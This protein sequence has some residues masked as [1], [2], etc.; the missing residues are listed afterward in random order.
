MTPCCF[1]IKSSKYQSLLSG[2]VGVSVRLSTQQHNSVCGKCIVLIEIQ[3]ALFK[4]KFIQETKLIILSFPLLLLLSIL[5]PFL[6]C[7]TL[8]TTT[9]LIRNLFKR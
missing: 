5:L 2:A 8:S 4:I 3:W 7:T 6:P 1:G 9:N